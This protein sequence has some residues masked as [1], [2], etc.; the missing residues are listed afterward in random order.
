MN[1]LY[2]F[3]YFILF[4]LTTTYSQSFE[5]EVKVI[6]NFKINDL[7]TQELESKYKQLNDFWSKLNEDTTTNLLKI[8]TELAKTDYS[9]YFYF[10]MTSYLQIN[11]TSSSDKLLIEEAI[12]NIDWSEIGTWELV[13]KLR[14]FAIND[15]NVVNA[16][17]NLMKQKNLNVSNPETKEMFNQGKIVCYLLLPLK[18]DSYIDV[19]NNEF[20]IALTEQQ[21]SIITLF[22]LSNSKEGTEKLAEIA[23]TT[24]DVDTR[25]YAN[26]L[27]Y[28][29]NPSEEQLKPFSNLDE[30]DRDQHLLLAYNQLISDWDNETWDKLI[31][32]TR[33][34]HYYKLSI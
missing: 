15:I 4:S 24:K 25:S 7:T 1:Q 11:S 26:R 13:E 2:L 10:D 33:I 18:A 17:L 20:K 6:Y 29:Y 31:L 3:F 32:T 16:V 8:R 14:E 30:N 5:E 28:R 23:K 34:M 9:S 22:W 27:L 21:R 19:L 12:K